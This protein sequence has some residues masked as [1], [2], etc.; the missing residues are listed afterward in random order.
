[1]KFASV[2]AALCLT[3]FLASWVYFQ[4]KEAGRVEKSWGLFGFLV[5]WFTP[6]HVTRKQ[7]WCGLYSVLRDPCLTR[8]TCNFILPNLRCKSRSLGRDAHEQKNRLVCKGSFYVEG[9]WSI[10][11]CSCG[12]SLC[13]SQGHCILLETWITKEGEGLDH[14]RSR[15]LCE[16]GVLREDWDSSVWMKFSVW[17]ELAW[18]L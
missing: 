11:L 6:G 15:K 1:M 16:L 3:S 12:W 8:Q 2:E 9:P 18:K 13:W 4:Q 10:T 17:Q 14:I 5:S 7:R